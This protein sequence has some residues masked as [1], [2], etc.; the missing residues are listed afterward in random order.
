MITAAIQAAG[1][2]KLYRRGLRDALE[3]RFVPPRKKLVTGVPVV[4]ALHLL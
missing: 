4:V 2:G 3:A 1:L